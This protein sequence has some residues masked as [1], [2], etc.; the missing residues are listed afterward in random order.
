MLYKTG[1]GYGLGGPIE[2]AVEKAIFGGKPG[3]KG[4]SVTQRQ[5]FYAGVL[6]KTG[7][8]FVASPEGKKTVNKFAVYA[9]LPAFAAGM[10][11][12][13]LVFRKRGSK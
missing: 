12:G 9:A 2:D 3:S 6:S 13:Y 11:V 7:Q 1:T 8:K 5:D 10:L 4:A